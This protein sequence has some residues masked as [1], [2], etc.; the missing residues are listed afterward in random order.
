MSCESLRTL[1][2]CCVVFE[3]TLWLL[4]ILILPGFQL[5]QACT[6]TDA[7]T[8]LAAARETFCPKINFVSIFIE[9]NC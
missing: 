6:S 3:L 2:H 5:L 4:H 7:L 1:Q 9:N 8:A